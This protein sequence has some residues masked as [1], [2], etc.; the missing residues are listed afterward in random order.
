LKKKIYEIKIE[1]AINDAE[2]NIRKRNIPEKIKKMHF[3]SRTILQFAAEL[4][5]LSEKNYIVFLID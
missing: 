2:Y 1:Q 4:E 5:S 3:T